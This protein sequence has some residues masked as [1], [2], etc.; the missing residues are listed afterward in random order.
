MFSRFIWNG[1]NPRI[2]Y[3]I[4]TASK[5]KGGLRVPDP[6]MYYIAIHLVRILS[7]IRKSGKKDWCGLEQGW[8]KYPLESALWEEG[9]VKK[10]ERDQHIL[11]TTT[12][13]TWHKNKLALKLT[14]LP[15]VLQPLIC[16]PNFPPS[17]EKGVYERWGRWDNKMTRMRDLSKR[18]KLTTLQELQERWGTH[19]RDLW[20]HIQLSHYI[21]MQD[22]KKWER[23]L[24]HREQIMESEIEIEKPY[25]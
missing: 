10:K 13:K 5:E 7:S 2:K 25:I 15:F 9:W 21:S 23:P 6:H 20:R 4:L 14:E 24:T 16:N 17:M 11:V 8:G 19:P 3:S 12:L 1:K 18:G 22:K